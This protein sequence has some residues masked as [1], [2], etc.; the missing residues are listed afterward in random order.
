MQKGAFALIDCLGFKGIWKKFPDNPSLILKK[1]D[2]IAEKVEKQFDE[3][4]QRE[5]ELKKAVLEHNQIEYRVGFFSDTVFIGF[6][7]KDQSEEDTDSQRSNEALLIKSLCSAVVK[8]LDLFIQ[9]EPN[10]TMRGCITYGEFSLSQNGNFYV[11][12]AVDMAAEYM[13]IAEGAFVWLHKSAAKFLDFRNTS[14]AELNPLILSGGI[15]R[16]TE[17]ENYILNNPEFIKYDMPIKNSNKL[18]CYVINPLINYSEQV[19]YTV[20]QDIIDTYEK[21][22]ESD[23]VQVWLK[24]QNTLEFLAEANAIAE[25][26]YNTRGGFIG[27]NSGLGNLNPRYRDMVKEFLEKEAMEKEKD[28]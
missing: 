5:S 6:Q 15:R 20:R 7:R 3:Y 25:T 11:G 28:S 12:P 23:N 22:M 17:K 24:Q 8:I 27:L 26:Y 4:A 14:S 9:G 1:L 16:L 13:N 21:A 19:H 18:K 2:S 10:L